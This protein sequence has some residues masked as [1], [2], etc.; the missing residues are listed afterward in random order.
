MRRLFGH[1]PSPATV[2]STVALIVALGGTSY[3]AITLPKNSVGSKQIKKNAVTSAKVKNSSLTGSD[4]KNSSLTG[5]DV[6]NGSLTGSDVKNG[7]LTGAKLAPGSVPAGPA[8]PQGPAGPKGD[9][10]PK[11]AT[12]DSP[13]R[14]L[15]ATANAG[16]DVAIATF[17]PFTLKGSCTG[18]NTNPTAQWTISTSQDHSAFTDYNNSYLSDF[19]ASDGDRNVEYSSTSADPTSPDMEGPYDGTFAAM[20]A[21]LATYITGSLSTGTFVGGAGNP[22]CEFAGVVFGS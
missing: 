10:G 2:I 21:D 5:S 18:T 13:T 19:S 20:S 7:S 11:G 22:P 3:A 17:G 6:K 4:V 15:K 1:R 12:G 9:T 14:V 16:D 8:G